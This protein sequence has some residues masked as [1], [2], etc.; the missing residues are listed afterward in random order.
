M[1]RKAY[2]FALRSVAVAVASWS[3]ASCA[4]RIPVS[5]NFWQHRNAK[6][7]VAV[8][9]ATNQGYF[10]KEGNQGLLDIAINSAVTNGPN[11]AL[12]NVKPDSFRQIKGQFAAELKKRGINAVE[13]KD[14]LKIKDFPKLQG[15]A[16]GDPGKD[17]SRVLD[18]Y[19]AD[20]LVVL[21]LNGY[22]SIRQYYGFLP[23]NS[24]SGYA[25]ATGF[26]VKRGESKPL[27]YTGIG[28]QNRSMAPVR[29][30]WDQG[31]EFKN[32][33]E[34]THQAISNS[35]TNLAGDFFN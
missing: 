14:D 17:Y 18:A 28:L 26:M 32:L 23:L 16:P 6:V 29:G 4:S 30:P 21:N 12:K 1:F 27:W 11:K 25:N 19:Q 2:S 33:I 9:T 35:R 31:P 10:Y 13:V 7:A 5:Q 22:G 3:L 8:S 15:G 24:P 34:A 20:Y